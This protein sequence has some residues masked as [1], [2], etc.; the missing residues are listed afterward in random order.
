MIEFDVLPKDRDGPERARCCSPTTTRTRRRRP[1]ARGGPRP[2]RWAP[3][4]DIELDV[5]LKCRVRAQ[6][7]R[8][9]R[10]R[11]L[12]ARTLVSTESM[13][14]RR[15]AP[16]GAGAAP[17]PV[18]APAAADYTRKRRYAV[19]AYSA[20]LSCAAAAA[21]SPP[22]DLRAGRCD[23][24]MA[25]LK[26]VTPARGGG[27]GRRRRALRV[28]GRRRAADRGARGDGGHGRHHQRPTAVREV[29]RRSSRW[30]RTSPRD[31]RPPSSGARPR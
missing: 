15:P 21:A 13:R 4:S 28:D 5:D 11:G 25:H 9:L 24:M 19:P 31:R 16:A 8:A 14:S 18:G 7:G 17:R 10:E 23:A 27:A 3:F 26:L 30:R 29:S 2:P 1:D 6:R 20:L 22:G 12:I